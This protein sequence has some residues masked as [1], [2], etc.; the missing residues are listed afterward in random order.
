MRHLRAF[1]SRGIVAT[2]PRREAAMRTDTVRRWLPLVF[3]LLL[4]SAPTRADEKKPAAPAAPAAP[5]KPAA[6]APAAPQPLD[7]VKERAAQLREGASLLEKAADALAR[8]NKSFA[9]Q[10]FSSAELLIGPEALV[11]LAPRFREGAPPRVTAPTQKLPDQGAQ[12]MAVGGSDMDEPVAKPEKG[13]LSGTVQPD[14]G[15]GGL[16]VVTLEPAKG[17]FKKRAPKTR[18][19]EQRGRQFSPHVLAVPV[20]S[21]V[22]FPN[23]DPTYH[24]V[25]ST[26]DAKAFDLGLYKNGEARQLVFDKEGVIRVGCN[27]HAN[28]SA[29]IVVVAAPHYAITDDKGGFT[30]KSLAPG[31]YTMKVWN[32][33]SLEPVVQTVEIK[34]GANTVSIGVK[35]DAPAGPAPDKF[36]VPRGK[37]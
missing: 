8:G 33:K 10:L 26:S 31:K 15:D 3:A 32:E 36:G 12:P 6:P 25:F 22:E 23:Y 16:S 20:G 21:T 27:L 19:M 9:E 11:D 17:K 4:A 30:F 35:G 34:P 14:K 1:W 28:M 29:F 37:N 18:I 13:T 7:P 2:T 24:N 5:Q